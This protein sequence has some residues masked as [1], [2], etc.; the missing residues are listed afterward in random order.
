MS[1][2]GPWGPGNDPT[3][4]QSRIDFPSTY[5]DSASPTFSL[6][7]T[8]SLSDETV[9]KL[10]ADIGL[11][12]ASFV[13]R[14]R[15]SLEA[16]LR[17]L[18]GEQTLEESL[19]WLKKRESVDL[20]S[21]RDLDS[22][23]SDDDDEVVGKYGDPQ[24]NIMEASDPMIDTSNA[25]YNV[26]LAKAC[27]ALW[28]DDGRLV[29]FFPSKSDQESSLLE[30]SIRASDRSSRKGRTMFEGFGRLQNTPTRQRRHASTL[31]T[32]ESG[33][34]D[35]EESS[36]SSDSSSSSDGFGLPQ[37]HFL[38]N[39]AWRGNV[40]ETP[41]GV[42]LDDSQKSSGGS[43]LEKSSTSK[44]SMYISIH[45]F[46]DILPAK[47]GLAERYIIGKGS[48]G[49]VQNAQVARESGNS[50]LADVWSFVD[51]LLQD[52]VPLELIGSPRDNDSIMVVARCAVSRLK[53]KDSAI[54]LS[55]DDLQDPK[56]LIK[57]ASVKWGN[58]PFGRRWFVDSLYASFF[59]SLHNVANNIQIPLL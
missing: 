39:M 20:D 9:S 40:L 25:Q 19:L 43:G 3:Y 57:S 18:L 11:I 38:P 31:E 50:D 17:Y 6:E 34:S 27:G 10:Y 30:M 7:K 5:P 12:T 4:L 2:S 41:P 53:A 55:F 52:I 13:S 46:D 15:N 16:T 22:S 56:T 47:Q 49:S 28:A 32:I 44:G 45:A 29:C 23:S 1:L 58:H 54:D 33:D 42:S 24:A 8:A 14:Q 35:F 37:H 36:T 48:V 59:N 26:P 51:L 21:T